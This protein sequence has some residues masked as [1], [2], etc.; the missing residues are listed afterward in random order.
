MAAATHWQTTAKTARST[1]NKS[2]FKWDA[3][4]DY[5][6]HAMQWQRQRERE[7]DMAKT[8]FLI[9]QLNWIVA[10]YWIFF[11]SW[12][13]A[14]NVCKTWSGL[15]LASSKR[16]Y[17]FYCT[18][19][20][21]VDTAE[22]VRVSE[23]FSPIAYGETAN[24]LQFCNPSLFHRFFFCQPDTLKEEIR[25]PL[26]RYVSIVTQRLVSTHTFLKRIHTLWH[27]KNDAQGTLLKS[28]WAVNKHDF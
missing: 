1:E 18:S 6:Y 15:K 26:V 14:V 2:L 24:A 5:G 28:I 19:S 23:R 27:R 3:F 10:C 9:N 22:S 12:L 7:R 21:Q 16:K 4:V 20:Y 13:R 17:F 11:F 25:Y 8:F